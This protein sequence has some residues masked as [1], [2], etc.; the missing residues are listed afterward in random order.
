M[1]G[2]LQKGLRLMEVDKLPPRASVSPSHPKHDLGL[3]PQG[4]EPL[5][6]LS[7]NSQI[8]SS[9]RT[10]VRTGNVTTDVGVVKVIEAWP[11]LN[12]RGQREDRLIGEA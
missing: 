9:L 5:N 4:L 7:E 2:V 11:T 12:I 8:S 6:E 1:R 10:P 3:P